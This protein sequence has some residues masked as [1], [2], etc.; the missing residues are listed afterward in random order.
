MTISCT[1]FRPQLRTVINVE[2][3]DLVSATF[4]FVGQFCR[5]EKGKILS[6]KLKRYNCSLLTD[7][8]HTKLNPFQNLSLGS[9]LKIFLK[10]RTFQ[11]RYCYKIYSYSKKEYI[12]YTVLTISLFLILNL[13]SFR[14]N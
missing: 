14:G 5:S 12:P 3:L 1:V 13:F 9:I 7:F 2:H 6:I 4:S 10:F 8:Q 11:P